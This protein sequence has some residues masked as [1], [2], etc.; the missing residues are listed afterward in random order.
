MERGQAHLTWRPHPQTC[1]N[2]QK[3]LNCSQQPHPNVF[4][5]HGKRLI[6]PSKG[7]RSPRL[8]VRTETQRGHLGSPAGGEGKEAG[9]PFGGFSEV[10][11]SPL[12]RLGL[13]TFRRR[14][15]HQR[16]DL[17]LTSRTIALH[18]FSFISLLWKQLIQCHRTEEA[19]PFTPFID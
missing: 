18:P 7:H 17:P 9:T 16:A 6:H 11:A 3:R 2:D 14:P 15:S 19:S 13:C 12:P 5:F 4:H 8:H 10:G 1:C